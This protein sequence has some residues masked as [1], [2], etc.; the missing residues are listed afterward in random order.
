M[1]L[2]EQAV[3]WYVAS[4]GQ[5]SICLN[6]STSCWRTTTLELV[7]CTALV[8]LLPGAC[9]VLEIKVHLSLP[10]SVSGIEVIS[11]SNSC[12]LR[13]VAGLA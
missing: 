7:K 9:Y 12:Q 10:P 4:G 8:S 2:Y 13:N 5:R 3:M 1:E 11:C 6:F